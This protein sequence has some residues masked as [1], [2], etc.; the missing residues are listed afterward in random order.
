[1]QKF[2]Q[3]CNMNRR[4]LLRFLTAAPIAAP[5]LALPQVGNALA[6]IGGSASRSTFVPLEVA[7]GERV[8]IV[9]TNRFSPSAVRELFD[10]IDQEIKS[11]RGV[12]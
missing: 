8:E 12:G 1:M 5:I 9:L 2:R 10:G 4:G 3:D 6:R 7:S 11:R